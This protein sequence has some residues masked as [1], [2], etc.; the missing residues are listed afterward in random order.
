MKLPSN[1][2]VHIGMA[3][4]AS[5]SIQH[6][7][8]ERS[9]ELEENGIR[10]LG[11]NLEYASNA[12]KHDWQRTGGWHSWL[13][14]R[15]PIDQFTSIILETF[16]RNTG[17]DLLLSNESIFGT[18]SFI[19]PAIR[20]L[21]S[22]GIN[23]VVLLVIRRPHEWFFSAYQQWA[24]KDK[25]NSGGVKNVRE[26]F[27]SKPP[28]YAEELSRW[29]DSPYTH[30][31]VIH[32][33]DSPTSRLGDLFREVNLPSS[34]CVA[35]DNTRTNESDDSMAL[36]ARFLYQRLQDGRSPPSR[37][38]FA[39]KSLASNAI[40]TLLEDRM[41][42]FI[43]M[44]WIQQEFATHCDKQAQKI[45]ELLSSNGYANIRFLDAKQKPLIPPKNLIDLDS[46]IV[47]ED[48][49]T[50]ELISILLDICQSQN[51]RLNQ[52]SKRV[53]QL[54]SSAHPGTPPDCP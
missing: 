8:R 44:E 7:L 52:L 22:H 1:L 38:V 34:L 46:Y 32:Q 13:G 33:L 24:L 41:K 50:L 16:E 2:F 26:W 37:F 21:S 47:D 18:Y 17:K 14:S 49:R 3:K 28:G 20:T 39:E 45:N 42:P 11:L 12:R 53:Q 31:L 23:I 5:S 48:T 54:E 36:I 29:L 30:R 9:S 43:D 35:L 27:Y 40:N 6:V 15:D 25:T 51:A 10:Y 19:E 4:C